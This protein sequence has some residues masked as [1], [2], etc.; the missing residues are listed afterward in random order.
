MTASAASPP[1]ASVQIRPSRTH[2]PVVSIQNQRPGSIAHGHDAPRPTASRSPSLAPS[3]QIWPW[4]EPA[5]SSHPP[6]TNP[7]L[8]PQPASSSPM[9]SSRPIG[10]SSQ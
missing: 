7:S 10:P 4:K 3:S 5:A 9:R 2:Q 1:L 8:T 6:I